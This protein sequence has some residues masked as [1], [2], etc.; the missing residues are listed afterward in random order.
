MVRNASRR[1]AGFEVLILRCSLIFLQDRGFHFLLYSRCL[2]IF[3]KILKILTFLKEY[4]SYTWRAYLIHLYEY[5][6]DSVNSI[7]LE[8]KVF[9]IFI[10]SYRLIRWSKIR[11]LL[12][13]ASY[14]KFKVDQHLIT[15]LFKD[16]IGRFDRFRGSTFSG[17]MIYWE[18]QL[19]LKK[20]AILISN[21]RRETWHLFM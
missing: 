12:C 5:T 8:A 2:P 7:I 15:N 19:K 11:Y 4:C 18:L 6:E 10:L 1:C 16:L 3:P 14:R 13:N 21:T 20:K 9:L 17:S